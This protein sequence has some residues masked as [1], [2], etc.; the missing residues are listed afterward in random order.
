MGISILTDQVMFSHNGKNQPVY[1]ALPLSFASPIIS[2]RTVF[3]W[4]P[5]SI[6]LPVL[7]Y[8]RRHGVTSGPALSTLH[9][10]F[11]SALSAEGTASTS[12]HR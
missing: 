6:G 7:L 5:L 10:C 12:A 1:S 11:R 2:T 8:R 9:V 3:P 4:A